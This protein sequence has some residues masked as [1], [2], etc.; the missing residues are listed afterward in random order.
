MGGVPGSILHTTDGGVHWLGLST[1][2][3]DV[4]NDVAFA[5]PRVGYIVG[6]GGT[7]LRTSD[8]GNS[9]SPQSSV[10]VSGLHSISLVDSG[11]GIVVGNSGSIFERQWWIDLGPTIQ[12]NDR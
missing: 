8:G 10:P 3:L 2:I 9:W 6:L 7:I 4:F 11:T 1:S 5:N 12:R